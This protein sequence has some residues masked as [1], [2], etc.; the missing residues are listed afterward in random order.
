M[1]SA[2]LSW[3]EAMPSGRILS[4]FGSDMS[5]MD[6]QFGWMFDGFVQMGL[7]ALLILCILSATNLPLLALC[8]IVIVVLFYNSSMVFTALR[9]MKRVSNNAMSPVVTNIGEAVRGRLVARQ[10][11]S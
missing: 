10:V 9:E 11:H 3:F 8:S 7:S 2:P 5:I 4:R 1:L 6:V